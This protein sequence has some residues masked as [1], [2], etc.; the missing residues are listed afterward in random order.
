MQSTLSL[1]TILI[2]KEKQ[3]LVVT[4][5]NQESE[6]QLF[7]FLIS[8]NDCKAPYKFISLFPTSSQEKE[9]P[10]S[11]MRIDVKQTNKH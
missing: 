8:Q 2:E 3:T 9:Q 10:P 1:S 11:E 4:A 5:F 7:S 6:K